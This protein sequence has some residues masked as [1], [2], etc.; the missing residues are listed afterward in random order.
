MALVVCGNTEHFFNS[1][2]CRMKVDVT[3]RK[4]GAVF[5]LQF[6]LQ[7]VIAEEYVDHDL[8]GIVLSADHGRQDRQFMDVS[9]WLLTSRV[10]AATPKVNLNQRCKTS[11]GV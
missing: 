8:D 3:M 7:F 5:I 11:D 6:W 1:F 9:N 10:P 4:L 2:G